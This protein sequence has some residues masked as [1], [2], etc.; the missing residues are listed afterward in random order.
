MEI[1]KNSSGTDFDPKIVEIFLKILKE[2]K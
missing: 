1:I 2:E